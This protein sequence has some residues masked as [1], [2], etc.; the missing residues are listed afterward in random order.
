MTPFFPSVA[1]SSDD[2]TL[3]PVQGTDA[4]AVQRL[5]AHPD[6]AQST[7]SLPHPYPAGEGE[8]WVRKVNQQWRDGHVATFAITQGCDDMLIGVIDLRRTEFRHVVEVGFW[9][10]Q[11]YWGQGLCTKALRL[12]V[13]FAFSH[14][15]ELMRI[16]AIS[17]PENPASER[18]QIKAGFTREGLLR[19]GLA[20]L[21]Q[22]R[23]AV[24]CAIVREDWLA[25]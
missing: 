4:P 15:P 2:I 11:P 9:L 10:G 18:V 5:A 20:R 8:R 16:F 23:D 7:G 3:R 6:V 25:T 22:P 24:L 12:M 13:D 19:H 17:F 1:I 14:D 21:D